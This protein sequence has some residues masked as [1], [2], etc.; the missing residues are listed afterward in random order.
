[1]P[2]GELGPKSKGVIHLTNGIKAEFTLTEFNPY[3]N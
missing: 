1:M 3:R 2:A